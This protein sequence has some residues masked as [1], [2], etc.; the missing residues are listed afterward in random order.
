MASIRRSTLASTTGYLLLSNNNLLPLQIPQEIIDTIIDEFVASAT[1]TSLQNHRELHSYS[2]VSRGFRDSAYRHIFFTVDIKLWDHDRHGNWRFNI[3]QRTLEANIHLVPYV[4]RIHIQ[5]DCTYVIPAY[6]QE[7]ASTDVARNCLE[8]QIPKWDKELTALL[9]MLSNANLTDLEISGSSSWEVFSQ[10]L[11]AELL[12]IAQSSP[13]LQSLQLT[14]L[15]HI[16]ATIL[17]RKNGLCYSRLHIDNCMF[18]SANSRSIP[19]DPERILTSTPPLID[20]QA[21][22]VLE[23]RNLTLIFQDSEDVKVFLHSPLHFPRLIYANV[24]ISES[25]RDV[26]LLNQILTSHAPSFK[27][28]TVELCRNSDFPTLEDAS[29]SQT[30]N[31]LAV[32]QLTV[33]ASGLVGVAQDQP[34]MING[35]STFLEYPL[36]PRTIQAITIEFHTSLLTRSSLYT[37]DGRIIHVNDPPTDTY[38]ITSMHAIDDV[39]CDRSRFPRLEKLT[40]Q[41]FARK[42][43]IRREWCD[44]LLRNTTSVSA[45]AFPRL[46][47]SGVVVIFEGETRVG[48]STKIEVC[49]LN[50][51]WEEEAQSLMDDIDLDPIF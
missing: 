43:Y 49:V 7:S 19:I 44:D 8:I 34:H 46:H 29:M 31:L 3:L 22:Q 38:F 50:R 12:N 41:L 36:L 24:R 35:I 32:D 27:R 6:K 42:E 39:L 33:M 30:Y 11:A 13:Y 40:V 47:A 2:L 45:D 37:H 1:G 25:K 21:L 5:T 10:D 51:S 48:G 15:D 4:R 16:P 26:T 20:F 14:K 28:L 23:L 18:L 9:K 17:A